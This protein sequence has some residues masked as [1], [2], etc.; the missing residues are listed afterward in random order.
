MQNK[1][2]V[3]HTVFVLMYIKHIVLKTKDKCFLLQ[4]RKGLVKIVELLW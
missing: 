2:S 1:L 4:I 3:Y